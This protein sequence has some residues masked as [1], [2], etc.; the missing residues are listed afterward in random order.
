MGD[1]HDLPALEA[2]GLRGMTAMMATPRSFLSRRA[3]AQIALLAGLYTALTT[4]LPAQTPPAMATYAGADRTQRLIDGARKEGVVTVYSSLVVEDMAVITA[5]FE[6]KYGVKARVWRG[7]SENMLQ[8]VLTEARG[9]RFDADLFETDGVAMESL[10]REKLLQPY[11]SP[12][13][14][15]FVPE[16]IA[17]HREWAG[18]RLN[19]FCAAYNTTLVK[20][21]E[22]PKSYEDLLH[23]HWK[24]KLAIEADDRDWTGGLLSELGEERGLKLLRDIVTANGISV[25]KGHTLLANLVASG[26]VP[27]NLSA[28]AHRAEQ[29]KNNGA[30]ID[31]LIIP[32]GIARFNGSG[33]ARR[34]PHPHAAVLFLDFL[35]SDAQEILAKR[36]LWPANTQVKPLPAGTPLKFLDAGKFLDEDEKWSR[37]HR[38]I[39]TARPR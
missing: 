27:M 11:G 23:P 12:V 26:E 5:A 10:H 30:P 25:R 16:A 24:G 37:Y 19:I 39:I 38:E 21:A 35:L 3:A 22:L 14:A 9:N 4:P 36:D 2:G 31:W 20:A 1:K 15:S 29:M 32:P 7:S 8:R 18:T 28:Y 17:P 34:A 13:L 33:I 6:R